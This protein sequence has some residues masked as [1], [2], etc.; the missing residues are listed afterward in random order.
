MTTYRVKCININ[1]RC[2]PPRRTS[3][4]YDDTLLSKNI[5]TEKHTKKTL[6]CIKF[7]DCKIKTTEIENECFLS[8]RH[9]GITLGVS[10]D[11]FKGIV[12]HHFPQ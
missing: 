1:L 4:E 9:I 12:R 5:Y 3:Y 6:E 8:L 11:T 7:G 10:S 2:V